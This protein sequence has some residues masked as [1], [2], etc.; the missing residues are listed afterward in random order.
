MQL[1]RAGQA[2]RNAGDREKE[3]RIQRQLTSRAK[4]IA[5][6]GFA[7]PTAYEDWIARGAPED[8]LPPVRQPEPRRP[9]KVPGAHLAVLTRLEGQLNRW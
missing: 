5:R 7:S 6:L 1:R 4:F 9:S 3:A 8:E 2:A